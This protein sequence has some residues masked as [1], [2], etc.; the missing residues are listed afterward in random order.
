MAESVHIGE[1]AEKL[2]N[3]LFAEFFWR[4]EGPTN[5]DWPC[6]KSELHDKRK[7]HP[8]DVVFW[9]DEPY[10][11]V[12]TYVHCDLKSFA[13]D[14]VK[15]NSVQKAALSLS[16]Q[17]E[18]ADVS[19]VWQERYKH[20]NVNYQIV[21]L[22]FV[23]NHDNIYDGDFKKLL[24]GVSPERLNLPPR[25]RL[26]IL[27]PDDIKWLDSIRFE[28]LVMRDDDGANALPRRDKCRYF[29][30]H[31]ARRSNGRP[32]IARAANLEMLSSPWIILEYDHVA[33]YAKGIVIFYRRKA[34]GVAEFAYLLD[35]LRHF[36]L[37]DD[38]VYIQIKVSGEN[39]SAISFFRK[40]TTQYIEDVL[41]ISREEQLSKIIDRISISMMN[42]TVSSFSSI[43]LGMDYERS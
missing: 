39:S 36:Q 27:G 26:F 1:I 21:G 14:S 31:L 7:T 23:Y 24:W 9:Y 17:I 25:S 22:L 8:A 3:Q 20:D 37:L 12:R 34:E 29:Y 40:A 28:L 10:K 11:E 19:E 15:T 6:E 41:G 18:C 43:A 32:G 4:K 38:G 33:P 30:P 35:Y 2:S 16:Q 13:K 42:Q 5:Q